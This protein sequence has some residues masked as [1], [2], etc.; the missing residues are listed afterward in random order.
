M[1]NK[2]L[3][4]NPDNDIK[5][6]I[7]NRILDANKELKDNF[8]ISIDENDNSLFVFASN[9]NPEASRSG[10]FKQVLNFLF[11]LNPELKGMVLEDE[12]KDFNQ[13]IYE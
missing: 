4:K 9:K 13:H 10:S 1:I 6:S 3:P 7:F 2:N 11:D 8:T 5:I 12:E